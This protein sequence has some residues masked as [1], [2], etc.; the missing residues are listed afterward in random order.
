MAEDGGEQAIARKNFELGVATSQYWSVVD[1]QTD[2]KGWVQ[3]YWD[4]DHTLALKDPVIFGKVQIQVRKVN[5]IECEEE[6][7]GEATNY[8]VFIGK[9]NISTNLENFMQELLTFTRPIAKSHK[10]GMN[11]YHLKEATDGVFHLFMA[12]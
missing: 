12:D 10:V 7:A 8:S 5:D 3:E 11:I 4:P 1:A 2:L 9:E 6:G